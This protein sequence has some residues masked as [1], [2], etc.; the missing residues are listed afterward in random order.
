MRPRNSNS[1]SM[2]RPRRHRHRLSYD[3]VGHITHKL[4]AQDQSDPRHWPDPRP[5]AAGVATATT[6]RGRRGAVQNHAQESERNFRARQP[7]YD[8]AAKFLIDHRDNELATTGYGDA[9]QRQQI[10]QREAWEVAARAEQTGKSPAE[11]VYELA[12]QRGFSGGGGDPLRGTSARDLIAMSNKDFNR[13]FPNQPGRADPSA[14]TGHKLVQ[15]NDADFEKAL[16][17][18][19]PRTVLGY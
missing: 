5:A 1:S 19:D 8:D 12:R 7:D 6:G 4:Q 2:C 18:V 9:K 16:D 10:L 3:P 15:M 13:R 14:L 17:K 11:L